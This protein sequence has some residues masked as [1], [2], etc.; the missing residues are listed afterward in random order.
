VTIVAAI[1]GLVVGRAAS[2]KRS[3]RIVAAIT[4]RNLHSTVWIEAFR[5]TPRQ[6]VRLRN[7][8]F[9]F[10]GWLESASDGP[11]ERSLILSSVF[12]HDASGQREAVPGILMLV[13]AADFDSIVLLGADVA[14]AYDAAVRR[15]AEAI[16]RVPSTQG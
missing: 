12:S 9:D 7:K 1:L 15:N 11:T 13:D 14:A 3:N 4:G 6:W 16:G 2:S 10:I 5:N 8:D